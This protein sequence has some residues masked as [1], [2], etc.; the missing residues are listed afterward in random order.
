[1]SAGA[2]YAALFGRL[3]A[4]GEAAFVPFAV[5]GDP[6]PRTSVEVV[7]TLARAG[8]DALEL[9]IPFSDPVAD[10]PAIQA[11]DRRA[12]EAGTRVEDA[13]EVV[14]AIRA[15][16]PEHPI[17]LLVYANLVLRRGAAAFYARAA[18]AGVDSVLVADAPVLESAPFER[19]AAAHGIAPVLIAPPNADR[20]RL[21]AIA[22][23]SRGFVYV[24]SRPGVT[25]ADED[26]HSAAVPVIAHLRALGSAPPL[27]GFGV[28]TPEHV[29]RAVA[30]GA[31]GAIA[32]SAVAARIGR[33]SG[34]RPRLL[35]AVGEFVGTM[36]R[37]TG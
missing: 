26:L 30:M 21:A 2:R 18:A 1:V 5:L 10:G 14:T 6:D 34:E 20:V 32:G 8:G 23:R 12:L 16:F 28:S 22:A 33:H 29:R 27:V 25:G 15:E 4:R 13:W 9:G 7:R 35:A 24:V 36:K 3:A 31:A 11:A 37:S 19:V 17:G